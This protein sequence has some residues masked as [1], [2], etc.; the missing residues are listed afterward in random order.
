[1]AGKKLEDA[2]MILPD[3]D[4][5][6]AFETEAVRLMALSDM[7]KIFVPTQMAKEIYTR[8]YLSLLR[9]LEKKES[10]IAVKQYNEN[11]K[12]VR[13]YMILKYKIY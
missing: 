1:M 8:M 11:H 9:S 10:K 6:I 7:Y 5:E 4:P 2:L 13:D 12:A 3:Y